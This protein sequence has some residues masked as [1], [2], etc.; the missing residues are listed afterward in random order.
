VSAHANSGAHVHFLEGRKKEWWRSNMFAA[1]TARKC[2]PTRQDGP[3]IFFPNLVQF[4]WITR[5]CAVIHT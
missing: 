1:A 5:T 4:R 2:V 3:T